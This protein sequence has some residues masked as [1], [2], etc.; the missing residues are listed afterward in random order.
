MHDQL[1]DMNVMKKCFWSHITYLAWC[2]GECLFTIVHECFLSTCKNHI[3]TSKL[4]GD[5]ECL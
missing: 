4:G 5:Q 1:W 3:G 2:V